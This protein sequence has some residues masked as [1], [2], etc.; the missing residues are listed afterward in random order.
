VSDDDSLI[1]DVAAAALEGQVRDAAR[2]RHDLR[3]RMKT[4]RGKATR[5]PSLSTG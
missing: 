2:S 1:R 3:R 5:M 4:R